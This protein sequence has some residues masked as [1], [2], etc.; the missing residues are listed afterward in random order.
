MTPETFTQALSVAESLLTDIEKSFPS[1]SG[2]L[3]WR[4][5]IKYALRDKELCK[6]LGE[7]LRSVES[8]LQSILLF[9]Q[10]YDAKLSVLNHL[11]TSTWISEQYL[12]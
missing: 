6:T 7:K 4:T 11:L 10:R 5:R 1:T 12:Q 3:K 2:P 9:E 8:T